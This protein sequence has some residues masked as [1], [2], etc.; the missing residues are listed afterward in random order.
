[1]KTYFEEEMKKY[2]ELIKQNTPLT[3][4]QEQTYKLLTEA[5]EREQSLLVKYKNLLK[6]Y[7]V[8]LK[9]NLN[10]FNNNKRK[11][12]KNLNLYLKYKGLSQ[13]YEILKKYQNKVLDK[14]NTQKEDLT[15]IYKTKTEK[16]YEKYS[17]ELLKNSNN[18]QNVLHSNSYL[19][20]LDENRIAKQDGNTYTL[21]GKDYKLKGKCDSRITELKDFIMEV[22]NQ[23]FTGVFD[24]A[25]P[26]GFSV[27]VR[28]GFLFSKNTYI[29]KNGEWYKTEKQ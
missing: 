11:Y 16:L 18:Y 21:Y 19:Y 24:P 15:L 8:D 2:D 6:S 14:L 5:Y 10:E 20:M 9:E 4:K 26:N 27:T 7:N 1:M 13:S 29:Y 23:G 28:D 12:N 17:K 22:R 25:I 3:Y